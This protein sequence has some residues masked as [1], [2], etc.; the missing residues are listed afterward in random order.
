MNRKV[1]ALFE[2]VLGVIIWC[3]IWIELEILIY[4]TSEN[5]LVDN[6]MTIIVMPIIYF[7]VLNRK[8]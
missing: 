2:T 7:A 6:I 8:N 1:Y 4:G 3:G 5:R